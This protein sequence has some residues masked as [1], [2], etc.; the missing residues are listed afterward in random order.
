MS[1]GSIPY[2]T[3]LVITRL[4]IE[5]FEK[6]FRYSFSSSSFFC[7]ATTCYY[8][9]YYANTTPQGWACWLLGTWPTCWCFSLLPRPRVI[10]SLKP[11]PIQPTDG[12]HLGG[13]SGEECQSL[14]HGFR[15]MVETSTLGWLV[16]CFQIVDQ[17][18]NAWPL[19]NSMK[20]W[21]VYTN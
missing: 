20:S 19:W 5:F 7:A 6:G 17:L 12:W 11:I 10:R 16:W 4:F 14:T 1:V 2:L 3:K 15:L 13:I 21:W 9:L 18:T 8:K